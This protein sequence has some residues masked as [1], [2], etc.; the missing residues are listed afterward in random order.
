MLRALIMKW[1]IAI[2]SVSI[3]YGISIQALVQ[4]IP[5]Y[6]P[7]SLNAAGPPIPPVGYR[8]EPFGD[9]AY[10]VTE[11]TYQSIFVV[12][13]YGVI[14][15]DCPPTI[16][17]SLLYAI[18]N[19]T[20]LPI[21]H[22]VYSHSH[23]DHIG[24]ASLVLSSS[25]TK[26]R[27]TTIAHSVTSTLLS[28][29]SDPNRPVPEV[30]FQDSYKLRVGNQTLKLSYKGP[31]HLDGNIFIYLPKQKVLML[32][33]VVYPGWTPFDRLGE[34]SNLPG[35]IRAHDQILSYDFNHYVGG[36]LD[37]SGTRQDVK[38]QREYVHDL[39][40]NCKETIRLT[41]TDD[42]VL[43]AQAI[44]GAA[45]G[46]NP[47]NP[48]AAFRTYLDIAAGYCANVTNEKWSTRLAAADV[49]QFSNAAAMVESLRIDYGI[50]G[51]FGNR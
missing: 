39:Y 51:P 14:V 44:L 4:P 9:G 3:A 22:L 41:T 34:V 20:D 29:V 10:M 2:T 27:I 13:T 18:G 46:A 17:H 38:I 25:P 47:G 1:F 49:F 43:G 36:H 50:L 48:W 19:T 8:V 37:R 32:V 11:G 21:T 26:K 23:A 35:Y 45:L 6:L 30:T 31:N 28:R 42:P 33:D 24:G 16:G 15:V 40:D 5:P 12:S 7:I